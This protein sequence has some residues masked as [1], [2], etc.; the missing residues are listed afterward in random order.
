[1]RRAL[2][3]AAVVLALAP[4]AASAYSFAG[5]LPLHDPIVDAAANF[6]IDYWAQRGLTACPDGRSLYIVDDLASASGEPMAVAAVTSGCDVWFDSFTIASAQAFYRSRT[7]EQ[8]AGIFAGVCF[9]VTHEFGHTVGLP[10]AQRGVMTAGPN[11]HW[12]RCDDFA[13][14]YVTEHTPA[15]IARHDAREARRTARRRRALLRN[16]RH[17]HILQGLAG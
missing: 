9:I 7:R 12:H 6:A 11:V 4:A 8:A 5:E 2:L 15:S 10:H 14:N 1:M 13:M 17:A 3:L 16:L